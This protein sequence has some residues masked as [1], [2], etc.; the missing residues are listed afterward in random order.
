MTRL[1]MI[2][3]NALGVERNAGQAAA[4]WER[5]A[6]LG[7]A[8]GQAMLGAAYQLGAGVKKDPIAAMTWLLRARAGGSA[9]AT[10]FFG[11]ARAALGADQFAEAERRAALPLEAAP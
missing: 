8:D 6:A 5:G 3:H 7:D 1:G 11:A 2:F 10:Q 4:W 9:L